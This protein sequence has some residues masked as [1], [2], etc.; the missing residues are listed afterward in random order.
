VSAYLC[1]T[2]VFLV[3]SPE[4][5]CKTSQMSIRASVHAVSAFSK[6]KVSETTSTVK[7]GI[8]ILMVW[9]TNF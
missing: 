9:E 6:P 2:A 7:P 8:D 3:I 5:T 1:V 4:M